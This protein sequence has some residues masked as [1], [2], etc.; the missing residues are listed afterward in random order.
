VIKGSTTWSN[1]LTNRLGGNFGLTVD[2]G[3]GIYQEPQE[4]NVPDRSDLR[5]GRAS[6]ILIRSRT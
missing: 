6:L 4:R 2:F 5:N 3:A 1:A